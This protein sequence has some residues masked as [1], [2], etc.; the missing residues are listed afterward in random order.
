[1]SRRSCDLPGR[2]NHGIPCLRKARPVPSAFNFDAS[3]FDALHPD[4]RQLVRR[5][6]DIEYFREGAVIL[7][8]GTEPTHLFVV[9]KGHVQQWDGDEQQAS[10]GPDDCFDG[11]GLVAGQ[12]SSR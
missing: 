3:P 6:V 2:D 9:I 4:E 11:R 8:P 5:S 10:F 1:M 7:S 12:V